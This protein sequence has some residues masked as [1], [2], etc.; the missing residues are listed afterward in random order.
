MARLI[1]AENRPTTSEER[2]FVSW[3]GNRLSATL[4][5]PAQKW[6]YRHRALGASRSDQ[7]EP[8]PRRAHDTILGRPSDGG[9]GSPRR[10][11]VTSGM[12]IAYWL[13]SANGRKPRKATHTNS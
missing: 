13:P 5:W 9:G 11:N 12:I 8:K 4:G 2:V 10:P 1:T 3:L 6:V 7:E